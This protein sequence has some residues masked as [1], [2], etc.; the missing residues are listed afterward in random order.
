MLYDNNP[1]NPKS[2]LL[3]YNYLSLKLDILCEYH[4]DNITGSTV[5]IIQYGC[6]VLGTLWTGGIGWH[7]AP[8]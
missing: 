2:I 4:C 8:R 1:I 6:Q 5:N 3:D 7:Q